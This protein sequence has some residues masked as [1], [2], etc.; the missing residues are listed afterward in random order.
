MGGADPS[1]SPSI[2]L[3]T[4]L[5]IR[6][7]VLVH[8]RPALSFTITFMM[9]LA[10]AIPCAFV[11]LW[12]ARIDR[13]IAIAAWLAASMGLPGLALWITYR[14]AHRNEVR[15]ARPD[16]VTALRRFSPGKDWT[17]VAD[18]AASWLRVLPTLVTIAMILRWQ[19]E[20][21]ARSRAAVSPTMAELTAARAQ[22]RAFD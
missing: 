3:L 8:R 16:E 12:L 10:S 7:D 9:L 22:A 18:A 21:D 1:P 11:L 14:L 13:R 4:R 5:I 15:P 6:V 2:P 20:A 17:Y 19:D